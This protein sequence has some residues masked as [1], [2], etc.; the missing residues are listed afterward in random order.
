MSK[1]GKYTKH[2]KHIARRKHFVRNGGKF[3]FHKTVLCEGGM[4]LADIVTKIAREDE[5][6]PRLVYA[7]V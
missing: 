6:N 2:T 5:L 4:K 1:N 3:N 7:M